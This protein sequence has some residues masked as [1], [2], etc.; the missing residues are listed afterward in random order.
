[1]CIAPLGFRKED[2][3]GTRDPR[4]W[5]SMLVRSFIAR[6]LR[7]EVLDARAAGVD[8]LVIRP[9]LTDLRAHGTN[10]MRHFD[11]AALAQSAR[12][13]T[14]RLLEENAEHPA[15]AAAATRPPR[16]EARG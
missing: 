5:S 9:W 3:A 15:L 14:L 16:R 11:R 10:S 7:K 13:G 8:V 4:L 1:V 12:E 2:V 6:T